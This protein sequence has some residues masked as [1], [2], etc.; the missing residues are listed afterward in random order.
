MKKLGQFT[1]NFGRLYIHS[2]NGLE[3]NFEFNTAGPHILLKSVDLTAQINS[4]SFNP[5]NGKRAAVNNSGK[6]NAYYV[7][8]SEYIKGKIVYRVLPGSLVPSERFCLSSEILEY[9]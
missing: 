5:Q 6:L 1:L 8:F 9:S 4:K 2:Y 7:F 3:R